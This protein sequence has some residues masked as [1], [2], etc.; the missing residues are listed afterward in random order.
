MGTKMSGFFSGTGLIDV[1]IACTLLEWLGLWVWYRIKGSGL[2]PAALL[3]TLLSGLCLMLALRCAL[4]G[5]PQYL[6]MLFLCAAGATHAA[7]I[8]RRW[9][10]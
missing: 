9:K 5:L 10:S 4:S 7:D 8:R 3:L 1:V 6:V 2:A